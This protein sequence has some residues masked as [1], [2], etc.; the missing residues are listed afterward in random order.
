VRKRELQELQVTHA[1]TVHELEKT[2]ALL[3]HQDGISKQQQQRAERWQ[4][5]VRELE[6]EMDAL[7]KEFDEALTKKTNRIATLE[8]QIRDVAYGT[9]QYAVAPSDPEIDRD[10]EHLGHVELSRGENLVE[11]CV[12]QARLTDAALVLFD[13]VP[14]TFCTY[15]FFEHESEVTPTVEGQVPRCAPQCTAGARP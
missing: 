12:V 15:D 2:R 7:R 13:G 14:V 4:N 10:F 11:L 6:R 3:S 1:E 5:K 9:H 8:A